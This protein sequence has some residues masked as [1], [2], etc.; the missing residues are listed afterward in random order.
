MSDLCHQE[1]KTLTQ[2]V[3]EIASGNKIDV[4]RGNKRQMRRPPFDDGAQPAFGRA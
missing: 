4:T 3:K 2:N 1:P